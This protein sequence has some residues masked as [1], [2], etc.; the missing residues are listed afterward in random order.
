L[1]LLLGFSREIA[2]AAYLG[3]SAIL[4][5][6]IIAFTVPEIIGLMLLNSMAVA[7][8]PYLDSSDF[9]D[10]ER[11]SIIFWGGLFKFGTVFLIISSSVFLLRQKILLWLAP[12]L[13]QEHFEIG[14][15][16]LAFLSP[17]ILFRGLESFF[18]SI[19]FSRK[20]FLAPALS[21]TLINGIVVGSLVLF[22]SSIAVDALAWGW[23]IGS[24]VL[25]LY[26][27]V[28]AYKLVS[29]VFSF[30]LNIDKN[31]NL[32]R[33]LMAVA[34]LESASMLY[35]LID[36][37]LAAHV[38]G[39]GP[40]AALRYAYNLII[41]PSGILVVAFNVASFPWIAQLV[42]NNQYDE[43]KRLQSETVR[44]LIFFMGFVAVTI[45]ILSDN[46]VA[47]ALQ[48]GQFD[49]LSLA[50]TARPLAIYAMG[51][52]FHSV[53]T[54]HMRF[55][56]AERKLLRLGAFLFSMLLLKLILS[57]VLVKKMGHNGLALATTCAMIVGAL[58]MTVD[59]SRQLKINLKEFL[60]SFVSRII[61]SLILVALV[62]KGLDILWTLP[63]TSSLSL[64]IV[65]LAL[66]TIFGAATYIL[67]GKKLKLAEPQRAWDTILRK[68]SYRQ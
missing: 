19:C 8:I 45:A 9:K 33:A 13:S 41:I 17:Y 21:S 6:F 46:I 3:T 51:I 4:E 57:T 58:G 62:I 28:I 24:C 38:L 54:F 10:R 22:S 55:Y 35:P 11:E 29:P 34:A 37:F 60:K 26:N 5:V 53:Y 27:G 68:A 48:R 56:Y 16:L 64:K 25:M 52:A 20:H 32:L 1:G 23:L 43:L 7:V 50:L 15:R 31:A 61:L 14:S 63:L 59:V 36:R 40:I 44:L 42:K 49:V 39:T 47:A 65:R 18:R 67:V 66:I 2:I 30:R 12:E